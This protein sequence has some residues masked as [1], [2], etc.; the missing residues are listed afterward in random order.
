MN[1]LRPGL[2]APPSATGP[3]LLI[4]GWGSEGSSWTDITSA[5]GPRCR[6]W[7]P[8]LL[9]HGARGAD[10]PGDRPLTV[11]DLAEELWRAAP[12]G[13]GAW[14]LVGHSMGAQVAL[15]A[16]AAAPSTV[17]I[18]SVVVVDPAYGALPKEMAGAPSRAADLRAQG[19]AA[20]VAFVDAVFAQ[21]PGS[22]VHQAVREQMA[23]TPGSV[24][25]D[26]YTSMYLAP[27]AAG[28][29]P[30]ARAAVEA[31]RQPL[32]SLHSQP[33]A[34]ATSRS[35]PSAP[36]SRV[37]VWPGTSHYLHQERP[38][39]F[40]ALLVEWCGQMRQRAAR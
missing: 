33:G 29:V 7:A 32:L 17:D 23:R 19:A 3:F 25:A 21:H 34:A 6:T 35:L 14:T 10:V 37:E 13:V 28:S 1:S 5:L 39:E 24:L 8:D 31:L 16:A 30:G 4:H 20:A 22:P 2:V 36:G 11:R 18:A 27:G 38:D 9:G 26:L 15:A 12:V 40:A